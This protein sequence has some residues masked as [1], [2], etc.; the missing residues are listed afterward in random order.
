MENFNIVD[1]LEGKFTDKLVT[2]IICE[3]AERIAI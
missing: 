2:K 1:Q 3:E